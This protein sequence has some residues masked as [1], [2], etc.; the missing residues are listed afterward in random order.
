MHCDESTLPRFSATLRLSLKL[1]SC[2]VSSLSS[3]MV[4]RYE[5]PDTH[6]NGNSPQWFVEEGVEGF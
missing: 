2:K 4:S 6:I 5:T 3:P 1:T